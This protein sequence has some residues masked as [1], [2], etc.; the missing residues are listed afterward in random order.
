MAKTKS[1]VGSG[2]HPG[3]LAHNLVG[4]IPTGPPSGLVYALRYFGEYE[5]SFDLDQPKKETTPAD[6]LI[7]VYNMAARAEIREAVPVYKTPWRHWPLSNGRQAGKSTAAAAA[8]NSSPSWFVPDEDPV[9]TSWASFQEELSTWAARQAAAAV[10]RSLPEYPW[11]SASR[12]CATWWRVEDNVIVAPED[13]ELWF[14][15][16]QTT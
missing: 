5:V 8:A 15:M 9:V 7:R 1:N 16:G 11:Q 14:R 4:V 10:V 6:L 12:I 2:P 3:L 13:P